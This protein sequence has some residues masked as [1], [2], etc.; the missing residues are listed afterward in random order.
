MA[1]RDVVYK[2]TIEY[3]DS[4]GWHYKE[5]REKNIID[6]NMNLSCKLQSCRLLLEAKDDGLFCVAVPPIK[7]DKD[8]YSNVVEYI[9]RA[10]YGLLVGNFEFDYSD[11]EVRYRA[12]MSAKADVP[13]LRDIERSVD[14]GM[15][16]LERYGNG[17]VKNMMGYGSPEQDIKE[18]ESD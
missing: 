10:N 5:V 3:L 1:S 2:R 9:T 7:A 15:F 17:L 8:S 11:G 4:Q 14:I 18:A 12:F 6:F 13:D 16:M